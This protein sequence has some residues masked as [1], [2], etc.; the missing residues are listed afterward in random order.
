M[1]SI[2][3]TKKAM[4]NSNGLFTAV[5]NNGMCFCSQE[6]YTIDYKKKGIVVGKAEFIPYSSIKRIV[7]E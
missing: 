4:K 5:V 7:V 3:K 2:R 6:W 1:A